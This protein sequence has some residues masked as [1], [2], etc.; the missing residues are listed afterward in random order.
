VRQSLPAKYEVCVTEIAVRNRVSLS[1]HEKIGFRTIFDYS[2]G[3]E[4][5]AVVAWD[6]SGSDD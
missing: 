3:Q 6:V 5:W 4:D 1:S 2:D